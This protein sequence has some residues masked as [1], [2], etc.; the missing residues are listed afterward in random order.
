M[1]FREKSTVNGTLLQ[2]VRGNRGLDGKVR[3]QVLLSLGGCCIPDACRREIAHHVENIIS[4]QAE[5]L[6]VSPVIAKW[7]DLIID[8]MKSEGK[9][10]LVTNSVTRNVGPGTVADGVLLDL[11]NHEDTRQVGVL[12]P[13]KKAWDNLGIPDFLL[14]HGMSPRRILAAQI[15]VFNRLVDPCSENELSS[16]VETVA[17][18]ELFGDRFS[19]YGRD[20]YYRAGDDL[21]RCS[22][23]LGK[24]LRAREESLFSLGNTILLY[25]L[26][27]SYF[28][29]NCLEN[30][31]AKRSANSKEK[32]TDCPQ[33]SVGLVLNAEGFP[34][35]HKVF[36]G[37]TNDSKTILEI[38]AALQNEAGDA[39]RPTVVLDGGIATNA[40]LT[41]LLENNYDYIVNGKRTTRKNF[42]ED[43][44]QKNAFR[45]V[46]G[47]D[48]KKPVFVKRLWN[49]HE[50]VLLCRSGDRKAKEDAMVSKTEERYLEALRKLAERIAK[51]DGKL[52]LDDNGGR[53]TVDRCIGKIASRY[54]RASKFYSVDYD[55]E[56]RQLC[57]MRDEEKYQEDANLHGCYHLR[58]SRRDLS[59]DEIWLIYIMLTRVETAFHL[60]KGELGLRPVYHW[61]EERCDA[62]VWITILAYHLLRWIEYSLKMA[63]MDCTYQEVR[64]LLQTHCYTTINMPCCNGKEYQIRRPGKPDERQKLIYS[65]LGIDVSTLPVRKVVV[66]LASGSK[67]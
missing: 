10:D 61:K 45:A 19:L 11:V 18:D 44:Q 35:V 2:L 58:T 37:N 57:W 52:H 53:V 67:A 55:A 36:A 15:C 65:S 21:L 30:P 60:L 54:T 6:A 41:V 8:R 39:G 66:E 43:F 27:N 28:E 62:H 25:D 3:Q 12:L 16:W 49:G 31:K 23:E 64:R 51:R 1:Y 33:L 7:A 4:G 9:L 14:S 47:R 29:G 34:I 20:V 40:N 63:G 24:H 48:D 46:Q 50:A 22:T 56:S 17:A 42:A 26:T 38:V 5:L 13:L 59:D 32:R